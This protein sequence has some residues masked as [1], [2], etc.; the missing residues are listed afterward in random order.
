MD[1]F[2]NIFVADDINSIIH[3]IN[4]TTGIMTA[5]AGGA[6]PVCAAA[7][8][9][10]L[11]GSQDAAGDGCLAATF[12]K[13]PGSAESESIRTEYFSRGLQRQHGAYRLSNYLTAMYERQNRG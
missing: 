2:G 4:P 1:A 8:G 7:T 11:S 13:L 6:S 10:G 12:L 9:P 3:V 5:V